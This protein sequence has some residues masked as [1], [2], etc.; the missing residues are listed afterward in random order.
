MGQRFEI[1]DMGN[2]DNVLI[3]TKERVTKSQQ[4]LSTS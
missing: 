2:L 1:P 3:E 4:L